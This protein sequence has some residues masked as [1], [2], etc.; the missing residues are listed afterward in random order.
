[1]AN[2][3]L[4]PTVV[5]DVTTTKAEINP[6]IAKYRI[7]L[8]KGNALY[9]FA[10]GDSLTPDDHAVITGSGGTAGNW[11]LVRVA[12]R[13]SDLTDANATIQVGGKE[14][15]VL[16]AAT[17]S[18]NR[19]L[20]LGTTNAAAGDA[21]D[22]TRLDLTANTYAIVNGGVGAGTLCTLPASQRWW[23]RV[24]FDGTNWS[25]CAGGQLP[26]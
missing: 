12:R 18:A 8:D 4:S 15:R 6:P 3:R 14:W 2:P 16:P 25:L 5:S 10:P 11:I 22:I 19:T 1:M 26:S 17:L 21:I 13:G 20:T 23:I 9:R 24:E 7:H